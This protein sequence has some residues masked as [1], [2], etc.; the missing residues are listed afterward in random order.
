MVIIT[1][2]C[3]QEAAYWSA[4]IAEKRITLMGEKIVPYCHSDN[5]EEISETLKTF[6]AMK[7]DTPPVKVLKPGE[8]EPEEMVNSA[9]KNFKRY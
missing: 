9:F 5:F 7:K 8:S 3:K 1:Y 4:R 6:K 2:S